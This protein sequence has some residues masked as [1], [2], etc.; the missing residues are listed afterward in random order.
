M[1]TNL[2]LESGF[3]A[4]SLTLNSIQYETVDSFVPLPPTWDVPNP[5][6]VEAQTGGYVAVPS[7]PAGG[8]GGGGG[9]GAGGAGGQGQAPSQPSSPSTGDAPL[10]GASQ[11]V[12]VID[13]QVTAVGYSES[14]YALLNRVLPHPWITVES[15]TFV[16]PSWWVWWEL[17]QSCTV[18][19]KIYVKAGATAKPL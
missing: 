1:I 11:E 6:I 3:A 2:L 9:S 17:E 10:S 12:L 16:P 8:A 5:Q 18:S 15:T 14:F 19:F 13:V 7:N 4:S